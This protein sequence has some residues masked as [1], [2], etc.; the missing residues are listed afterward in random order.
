MA[1]NVAEEDADVLD[2]IKKLFYKLMGV[3]TEEEV[4]EKLAQFD[5]AIKKAKENRIESETKRLSNQK[6]RAN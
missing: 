6:I 3:P 5:Q 4:K 2:D 1:S